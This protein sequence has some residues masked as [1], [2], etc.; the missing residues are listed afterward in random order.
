MNLRVGGPKG[1]LGLITPLKRVNKFH[2]SGEP[3]SFTQ[4][5]HFSGEPKN[6][7]QK[8]HLTEFHLTD[9][10]VNKRGQK[11]SSAC[12]EATAAASA[13]RASVTCS[14]LLQK[15]CSVHSEGR[16]VD[17]GPEGTSLALNS[18]NVSGD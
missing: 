11:Q 3:K 16:G 6:F 9:F 1:T 7:T 4:K 13:A 18:G 14:A 2:F 12:G 10:Y 15:R 5:F 17:E 8:F